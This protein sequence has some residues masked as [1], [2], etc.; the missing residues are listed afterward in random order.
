MAT[1]FSSEIGYGLEI[2]DGRSLLT[3]YLRIEHVDGSNNTFHVGSR[4]ATFSNLNM[5]LVGTRSSDN[6]NGF[7]QRIDLK[8]SYQW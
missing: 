2:W 3:P 8:S 4:L 1:R 6:K 5:E 7:N